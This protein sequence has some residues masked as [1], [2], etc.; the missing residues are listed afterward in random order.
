MSAGGSGGSRAVPS[1]PGR[2]GSGGVVGSDG[3]LSRLVQ[4]TAAEREED[5]RAHSQV[6]VY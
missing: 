1:G 3:G 6:H 5:V 4:R 2:G